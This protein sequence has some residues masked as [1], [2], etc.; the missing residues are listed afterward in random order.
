M[1]KRGKREENRKGEGRRE[2]EG[3]REAKTLAA[4]SRRR[5]S[6]FVPPGR[7]FVQRVLGN[8]TKSRSDGEKDDG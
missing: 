6:L 1:T 7:Y 2:E 5:A 8:L 3:K 4:T